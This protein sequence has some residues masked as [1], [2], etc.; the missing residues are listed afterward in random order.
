[1]RHKQ[2][3]WHAVHEALKSKTCL[4]TYN[5]K[6]NLLFMQTKSYHDESRYQDRL[7]R[8][9]VVIDPGS[10]IPWK[11]IRFQAITSQWTVE[12]PNQLGSQERSN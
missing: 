8:L 9:A 4:F 5:A 7:I 11:Y 10:V 1:M 2:C 12:V 6:S 3:S